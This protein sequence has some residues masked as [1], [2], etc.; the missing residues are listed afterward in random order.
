[1]VADEFGINA[2]LGKD[3]ITGART[4]FDHTNARGG[5]NGKRISLV[6]KDD[7]GDPANTVR[8]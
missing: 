3:Y 2:G 5:I 8:C 7:A 6:V 1:M 4:Y